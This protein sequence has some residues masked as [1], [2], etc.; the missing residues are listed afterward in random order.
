MKTVQREYQDLL[1]QSI[2]AEPPKVPFFSP[3]NNTIVAQA[4]ELGASYWVQNLASPVLF[5]S[6]VGKVL[7]S[8]ASQKVFIEI[9]PYWPLMV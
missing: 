9:G 2:I 5:S 1:G 8:T 6:A 7:D 4:E 3:V